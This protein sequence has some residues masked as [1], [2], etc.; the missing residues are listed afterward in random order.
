MLKHIGFLLLVGSIAVFGSC[1]NKKNQSDSS[2]NHTNRTQIAFSEG[3]S[4]NITGSLV[5][6]HC[7]ALNPE[8]TGHD[9]ELPKSGYRED[10][11]GFCSL[12]GYP[13]AVL[14]DE[15]ID[16]SEIWVIRTAS[17]IFADY[18]TR[19]VKVSGTYVSSGV[20]EPLSIRLKSE[21]SNNWITIM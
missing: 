1:S 16:G 15:N 13:V 19:T 8:N 5:C 20:I 21:K 18:M 2:N 12:Q 4:L 17:Q 10:C 9:H 6:A 3:D 7:Y 11:A 14:L